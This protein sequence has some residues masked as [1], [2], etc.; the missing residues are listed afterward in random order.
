VADDH[1]GDEAQ[2]DA[3]PVTCAERGD[4][5]ELGSAVS[6]GDRGHNPQSS[7]AHVLMHERM[8]VRRSC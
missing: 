2:N 3:Q 5:L 1:A 6:D 4:A 8:H 7:D